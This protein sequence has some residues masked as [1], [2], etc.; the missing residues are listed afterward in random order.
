MKWQVYTGQILPNGYYVFMWDGGNPITSEIFSARTGQRIWQNG[1]LRDLSNLKDVADADNTSVYFLR[2][3]APENALFYRDKANTLY[4]IL[5][6]Q[7][8]ETE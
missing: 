6:T 1:T 5:P 2:L 8:G 4:S 3:I 7:E